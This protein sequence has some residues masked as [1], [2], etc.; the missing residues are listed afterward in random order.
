VA[1]KL[2]PTKAVHPQLA[3]ETKI[4]KMLASGGPNVGV[5]FVRWFGV[6]GDY[7][8]MVMDL[9]GPSLEDLFTF[10]SRKFKLKTV[11]L[12]ADQLVRAHFFLLLSF[13]LSF[14]LLLLFLFLF[15]GGVE[16]I[17]SP[18]HSSRGWSTCIQRTS[19]TGT[20]SR[21]TF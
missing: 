3:Y 1:I 6:E 14:F 7:N 12:L 18:V 11:L 9:L 10:C 16:L 15:F 21:T 17:F 4:Y 8:V 5:P 19:F 13:S 2:E 20:S